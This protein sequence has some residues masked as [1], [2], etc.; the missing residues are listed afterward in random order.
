MTECQTEY[1]LKDGIRCDTCKK[2]YINDDKSTRILKDIN[3]K[4]E[5]ANCCWDRSHNKTRKRKI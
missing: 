4:Y 3:G 5:C 2:Y 1:K